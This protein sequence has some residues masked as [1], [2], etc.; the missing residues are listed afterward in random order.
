MTRPSLIDCMN[1]VCPWTGKPVSM[2]ALTLYKGQVVGFA[3]RAARDHFLAAVV[4]F[5]TAILAPPVIK[6]CAKPV[7]R[8]ECRAA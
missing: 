3:S 2:D 7:L 8:A 1:D 5:E 6:G 4:A